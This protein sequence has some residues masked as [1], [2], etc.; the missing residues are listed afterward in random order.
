MNNW[1]THHRET[2]QLS[3]EFNLSEIQQNVTYHSKEG[4]CTRSFPWSLEKASHAHAIWPSAKTLQIKKKLWKQI[5][6]P[7]CNRAEWMILWKDHQLR[8]KDGTFVFGQRNS[9]DAWSASHLL[10]RPRNHQASE[11]IFQYKTT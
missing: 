4:A 9:R 7:N 1:Y 6:D 10:S 5:S 3:I 2:T 8:T 11:E